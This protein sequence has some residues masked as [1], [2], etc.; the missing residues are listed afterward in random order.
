M[1]SQYTYLSPKQIKERT[2]DSP[3][4]WAYIQ[5]E[6]TIDSNALLVGEMQKNRFDMG[7]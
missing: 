3:G 4:C 7:F 1:T 2:I 5:S 6:V